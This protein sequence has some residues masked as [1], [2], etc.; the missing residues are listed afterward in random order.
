MMKP[1]ISNLIVQSSDDNF[2]MPS[3]HRTSNHPISNGLFHQVQQAEL[4]KDRQ[5]Q[6]QLYAQA[7]LQLREMRERE[8]EL[9]A[10]DKAQLAACLQGGR[11]HAEV[12]R[13]LAGAGAAPGTEQQEQSVPPET[14]PISSGRRG[15]Q[16]QAEE[17]AGGGT[18]VGAGPG[19]CED[20]L[21]A[22]VDKVDVV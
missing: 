11:Q 10:A 20:V 7:M 12:S 3:A 13:G 17:D 5:T 16:S 21:A 9:L 2:S 19:P 8:A 14:E 1:Q 6:E 15:H 22:F 18:S 4:A